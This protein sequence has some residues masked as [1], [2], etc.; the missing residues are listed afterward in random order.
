LEVLEDRLAPAMFVVNT[1]DDTVAVDLSTGQDAAGI[2]SLRSALQA[3]NHLGGS[4]TISLPAGT[5]TLALAGADENN[6]ATGDLDIA[7]NLTLTGAGATS[8]IISANSLDRV[9][10]V[11]TSFSVT[12]ANVTVTGGRAT[13]GGGI[14]TSGALVLSA[15]TVANNLAIGI[16]GAIG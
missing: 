11:A 10:E 15:V 1:T 2:V 12:I 3:A 6:A 13:Q 16:D 7:N 14:F 4:N 5:Y 8:T 9:F